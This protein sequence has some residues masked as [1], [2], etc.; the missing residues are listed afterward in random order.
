MGLIKIDVRSNRDVA[1]GVD[2]FVRR[3]V[4]LLDLTHIARLFDTGH[5]VDLKQPT[6]NIRV[7]VNVFLV[8]LKV[9]VVY[10]VK[11][12]NGWEQA[13]ICQSG[14]LLGTQIPL[15]GQNFFDFIQALEQCYSCF[16]VCLLAPRKTASI[17]GIIHRI[18]IGFNH[19]F[20]TDLARVK[21][22]ILV[23]SKLVK[24]LAKK[25]NNVR[26]FAGEDVGKPSSYVSREFTRTTL[27][28]G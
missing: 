17:H 25:T 23:N 5:L 11:S 24:F 1:T 14:T 2:G 22:H 8:A 10:R 28:T 18:V 19:F 21:L 12:I 16:R 6:P 27:D 7:L 3:E 13:Q 15:R 26:R 20:N 9:R 4:V